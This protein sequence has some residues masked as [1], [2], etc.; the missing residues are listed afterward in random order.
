MFHDAHKQQLYSKGEHF[1]WCYILLS[2]YVHFKHLL[3]LILL[4]NF[5][6]QWRNE[7]TDGIHSP[8][9]WRELER[10]VDVCPILEMYD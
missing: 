5:K 7:S 9:S 4:L 8:H 3:L 2:M 1:F 10:Q 6:A